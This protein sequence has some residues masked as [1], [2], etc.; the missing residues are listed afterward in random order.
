MWSHLKSY[1]TVP[2][3][4]TSPPKLSPKYMKVWSHLTPYPTVRSLAL[5]LSIPPTHPPTLNRMCGHT[6]HPTQQSLRVIPAFLSPALSLTLRF[7]LSFLSWPRHASN[8]SLFPSPKRRR[9]R[10]T[11]GSLGGG[12]GGGGGAPYEEMEQTIPARSRLFW[13]KPPKQSPSEAPEQKVKKVLSL[14]E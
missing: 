3:G 10:R 14:V 2:K 9:R 13:R 6:W 8:P 4:Y 12:G 7:F 11:L 5:N 1:P